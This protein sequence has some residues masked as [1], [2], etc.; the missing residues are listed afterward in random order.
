MNREIYTTRNYQISHILS[1][2]NSN[3]IVI[4]EIQRPF[5]WKKK[6]VRDLLDSLFK[7]YP[8]GYIIIWNN[9]NVKLKDGKMS[10]GKMVIIDGQQRITALM[11]AIAGKKIIDEKYQSCR[12]KIAFNPFEALSEDDSAEIFAV[13]TPAHLKSKNW[14]PDIAELFSE[15]FSPISFVRKYC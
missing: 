10:S 2:I 14:I 13:Q 12:Y 6:Q 5:V 3:E 4:P 1:H 8:I 7:G 11:T 9:P 15:N